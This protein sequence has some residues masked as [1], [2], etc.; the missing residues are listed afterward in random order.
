MGYDGQA[1]VTGFFF[2]A[3]IIFLPPH[4]CTLSAVVAF[5]VCL[6]AASL[7]SPMTLI[8]CKHLLLSCAIAIL[9]EL[10]YIA[11][12]HACVPIPLYYTCCS[13]LKY[14]AMGAFAHLL[15][16]PGGTCS[17]RNVGCS[18]IFSLSVPFERNHRKC[19]AS[20]AP[21]A[22]KQALHT[23]SLTRMSAQS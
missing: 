16:M 22:S 6:A 4:L 5:I 3:Y 20:H 21:A 17:G 11:A 18:L 13:F 9:Y 1:R 7:S 2:A 8:Y 19:H 14:P 15:G 23:L 10:L 12:G